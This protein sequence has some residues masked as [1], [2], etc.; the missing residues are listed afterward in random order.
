MLARR[1]VP[2][3]VFASRLECALIIIR[4]IY[5]C[6]RVNALILLV[7]WF[8]GFYN[9]R[10]AALWIAGSFHRNLDF[11]LAFHIAPYR[12]HIIYTWSWTSARY[13]MFRFCPTGRVAS[14]RVCCTPI[15]QL[16][17]R[18]S[19]NPS[20]EPSFTFVSTPI[21]SAHNSDHSAHW[22]SCCKFRATAKW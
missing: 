10:T 3:R 11:E 12:T 4:Y 8:Y 1:A 6:D 9:A 20:H 19:S 15:P 2:V 7:I 14:L 5:S 13:W 21:I 18:G 22:N 17:S 16:D